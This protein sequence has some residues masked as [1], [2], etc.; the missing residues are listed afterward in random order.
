MHVSLFLI[1]KLGLEILLNSVFISNKN[2]VKT[3]NKELID[4]II[5]KE[6][7]ESLYK[8][9]QL[10]ADLKANLET[11]TN[12]VE[13]KLEESTVNAQAT[14]NNSIQTSNQESTFEKPMSL[15]V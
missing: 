11:A 12:I 15:R 2:L 14:L 1:N 10:A 6:Q 8:I 5:E 9:Q 7:S 4:E 3:F 13:N